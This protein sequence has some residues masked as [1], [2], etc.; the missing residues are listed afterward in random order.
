[1]DDEWRHDVNLVVINADEHFHVASELGEQ[2]FRNRYNIGVWAWELPSFPQEW[3]NRFP[4]YDEIWVGTSF[5]AGALAKVSPIPVVVVPPVM[6]LEVRGSRKRGRARLKAKRDEFV[7]VFIFDFHSFAE[8]KN[9]VA[10]VEAFKRAFKPEDNARLVIKCV[11]EQVAE[12]HLAMLK[13]CARDH[14]IDILCGYGR[15]RRSA[16]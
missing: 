16:I 1:M 5:I 12:A 6:S 3:H 11:N 10:A 4:W 8:R 9:P 14:R 2:N 13:A 15:C 7:F